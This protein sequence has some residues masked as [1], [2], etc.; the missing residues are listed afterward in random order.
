MKDDLVK[1]PRSVSYNPRNT[2]RAKKM[3]QQ[4]TQAEKKLWFEFLKDFK[5]RV[6]RQRPIIHY[7]ADFYCA[8]LKLVI[9]VDGDSHFNDSGKEYDNER[10]K[11]FESI[12]IHVMRFINTEVLDCFPEVCEKINSF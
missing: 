3:R 9:E 10:T 4:M 8:K 6:Y 11:A 2:D 5:Y 1:Y 7:I 12:G